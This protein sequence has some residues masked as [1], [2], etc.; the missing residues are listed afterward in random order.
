ML[1]GSRWKYPKAEGFALENPISDV[2]RQMQS[3]PLLKSSNQIS[4]VLQAN[5]YQSDLLNDSCIGRPILVG[6]EYSLSNSDGIGNHGQK[7]A[8]KEKEMVPYE[9]MFE[10]AFFLSHELKCLQVFSKVQQK[11]D[12]QDEFLLNDESLWQLMNEHKQGFSY[13]YMAYSHLRRKNW[14]VRAGIQYGVHYMAYRHHPSHVH[15]EYSVLVLPDWERQMQLKSWCHM[16][17]IIRLCGNVAKTLLLLQVARTDVNDQH[18]KCLES[19]TIKE[20]EVKRWLPQ[21][22][23][24]DN[25]AVATTHRQL[26]NNQEHGK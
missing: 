20:V 21:K 8:D 11:T 3:M 6:P 4:V 25:C 14:I 1:A 15:A 23:R 16:Q 13:Y 17:G 18:L 10:E 2:Y 22:H 5:P 9:L 12:R 7:K 19:Y 26:E 24:M